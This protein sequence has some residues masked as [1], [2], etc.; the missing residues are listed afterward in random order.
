MQGWD[1]SLSLRSSVAQRCG[2]CDAPSSGRAILTAPPPSSPLGL[3][4]R[5]QG[6]S[7]TTLIASTWSLSEQQHQLLPQTALAVVPPMLMR[8]L[9]YLTASTTS[10]MSWT[11]SCSRS[12]FIHGRFVC[13]TIT[14]SHCRANQWTKIG[15][16]THVKRLEL[17]RDF[18][19]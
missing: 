13:G 1:G 10:R 7:S 17:P 12:T 4:M 16:R 2:P 5:R 9:T 15:I 19:S 14:P 3:R 6:H 8:S 11:S 18:S